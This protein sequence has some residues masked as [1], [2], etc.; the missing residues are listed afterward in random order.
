MVDA[1]AM[2]IML[3]VLA[4]MIGGGIWQRRREIK[5]WNGGFCE[6]GGKWH[7][8]DQDSQGGRMYKCEHYSIR[9]HRSRVDISYPRVDKSYWPPEWG[10][11][12]KEA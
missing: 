10:P 2:G 11:D 8:F 7:S 4:F 12:P 6:C 3:A 1:I 5:Q 9:E